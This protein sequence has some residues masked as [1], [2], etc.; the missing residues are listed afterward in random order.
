[1]DFTAVSWGQ[2]SAECLGIGAL[3]AIPAIVE[4]LGQTM[5]HSLVVE[6][7]T[8]GSLAWSVDIIHGDAAV[9]LPTSAVPARRNGP[10]PLDPRRTWTCSSELHLLFVNSRRI[11]SVGYVLTL[12]P[13]EGPQIQTL[14]YIPVPG[15]NVIWV[16]ATTDSASQVWAAHSADSDTG[17][18]VQ[19]DAGPYRVVLSLNKLSGT[20]DAAYFYCSSLVLSHV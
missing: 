17:L 16:G 3:M 11:S 12:T 5:R 1:M 6:N 10:D 7:L 15:D 20:T 13:A 18:S 19:A 2:V 14:V 9:T 4:F 8:A